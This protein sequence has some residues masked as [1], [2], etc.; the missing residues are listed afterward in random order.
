MI[1]L[2]TLVGTHLPR[3]SA[4]FFP[5]IIWRM[6]PFEKV[7]YLT[8]DDGPTPDVTPRL[9]DVMEQFGARGTCFLLGHRATQNPALVREIVAA[10][11]TVG[12]HTYTHPNAWRTSDAQI[13]QELE[14]TT[15][16][17]EDLIQEPIRWMRPPYG[18]FTSTM[19]HWCSVRRQKCTMWDIGP[20]D[21]LPN[22]TVDQIVDRVIGAIR[23]GSIIVL[24][25]NM[26]ACNIAPE[27]LQEILHRLT[28]K[29][30]R[31]PAL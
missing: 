20:G 12:N 18:R 31:F 27:A 4:R 3:W 9:L 19:R 23:P 30:W 2:V 14:R 24:H 21:F 26:K 6:P 10:G 16:V 29:G 15:G 7:A 5:D 25:D 28:D 8:F 17:L 13:V 1:D 22:C 11:H